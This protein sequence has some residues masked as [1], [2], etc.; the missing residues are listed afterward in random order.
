MF[1]RF[2]AGFAAG[3]VFGARAG[4]KRYKQIT[5]VV[6]RAMELPMVSGLAD[7]ATEI[8]NA[9]HGRD[10]IESI[11][12]RVTAA[13]PHGGHDRAE[14]DD[15][16]EEDDDD[17][18]HERDRFDDAD[19]EDYEDDDDRGARDQSDDGE[20]EDYDEDDDR[21]ERDRFE[22]ADDEDYD[23]DDD[24]GERDE[25][26]DAGDEDDDSDGRGSSREHRGR[27]QSHRPSRSASS[28]RNGSSRRGIRAL[29]G[30]AIERGRLT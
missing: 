4:D 17:D 7:R 12:D 8:V 16:D 9:D 18:D 22:D 28:R 19:D 14:A 13:W 6:E 15:A 5:Q 29:A 24:R 26:E 1:K 23:E 20:D 2:S 11:R 30:A 27:Q 21:G 3:Y 10:L 25:F